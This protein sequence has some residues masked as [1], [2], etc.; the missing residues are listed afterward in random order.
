[1]TLGTLYADGPLC[2][3]THRVQIAAAELGAKIEVLY[4]EDI[5]AAAREANNSG[6]WPAFAPADGGELIQDSSN[7][8]D[9][10]MVRGGAAGEAYRADPAILAMLDALVACISKVILAGKPTIQR[11]FRD[12]LD[13][14]LAKVDQVRAESGG[15]FLGGDRFSEADG[16]I[17][18]FLYRLPFLVEIRDH[19]PEV[20]LVNSEFNAWVDR[21]VNRKSFRE[22]APKRHVL[23][24]FYAT[25]ASYGKPMKIG[26]LHHSGFRGMWDDVVARTSAVAASED[27]DSARLRD[28]RDLCY[29]LCRAVALHAKFENL[30][31]FPALDAA[32]DD[33]GFTAEA[34]EQ[35]DHEEGEMNAL[36]A[37]FD[38]ALNETPGSRHET[39]TR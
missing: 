17:A 8:T 6:S 10:L 39:L 22:I 11:E 34:V 20:F 21:V 27:R 32:K 15:P 19:L 31:L 9:H 2:P 26:R 4:G 38:R 14:M 29:L 36:L 33:P 37:K 16:H 23:R 12:K 5:P 7:I 18:P 30:L 24:Q 28:A 25:K 35:H 1:M 3:F 13:R